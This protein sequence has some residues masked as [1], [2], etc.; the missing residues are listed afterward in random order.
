MPNLGQ[1]LTPHHT[2]TVHV[3]LRSRPATWL[4]LCTNSSTHLPLTPVQ[5]KRPGIGWNM[6]C[7]VGDFVQHGG[8]PFSGRRDKVCWLFTHVIVE[9]KFLVSLLEDF[10][11]NT[12]LACSNATHALLIYFSLGFLSVYIHRWL[13]SICQSWSTHSSLI[14]QV[15]VAMK[16]RLLYFDTDLGGL[17]VLR[18]SCLYKHPF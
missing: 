11:S 10:V 17:A 16:A 18:R 1:H 9:H 15:A 7:T 3:H 5:L 13:F 2:D 6:S 14:C 12:R 4:H 8:L